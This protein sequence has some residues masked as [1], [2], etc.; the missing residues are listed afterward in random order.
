MH[1]YRSALQN[2]QLQSHYHLLAIRTHHAFLLHQAETSISSKAFVN[3]SN[4]LLPTSVI[5]VKKSRKR[6][7]T[8]SKFAK[9]DKPTSDSESVSDSSNNC[10]HKHKH[11]TDAE[12][13]VLCAVDTSFRNSLHFHTS[14]R[15]DEWYKY[16]NFVAKTRLKGAKR[17][18]MQ[19]K[20][21]FLDFLNP[22]LKTRYPLT[23]KLAET[24]GVS[25]GAQPWCIYIS[26][27][28]VLQLPPWNLA[29]CYRQSKI[30]AGRRNHCPFIVKWSLIFWN[31][32]PQTIP[33]PKWKS[34]FS[35]L[36]SGRKSPQ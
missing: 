16:N 22:S 27:E 10:N 33:F 34:E 8:P 29:W 28:K 9:S 12:P 15:A 11:S 21:N 26:S 2:T 3:Q 31:P 7:S 1:P 20:T 32:N 19:K 23:F 25:T 6:S 24:L 14:R 30:I 36:R 5:N 18:L 13:K 4:I 17:H 35:A